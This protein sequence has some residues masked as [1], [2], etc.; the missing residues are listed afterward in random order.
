M[1][2]LKQAR[3]IV[4]TEPDSEAARALAH[5]MVA[6][7][8]EADFPLASLYALDLETFSLAMKILDEWRLGRYYPQKGKLLDMAQQ[9]NVQALP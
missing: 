7:E 2:A 1:N 5:L 6:L 3:H 4:E 9:L 8:S